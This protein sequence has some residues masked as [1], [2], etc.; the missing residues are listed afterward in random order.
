[1][2]GTRL[3]GTR[4]HGTRLRSIRLHDTH[5]ARTRRTVLCTAFVCAALVCAA[6]VQQHSRPWL[7]QHQ[8]IRRRRSVDIVRHRLMQFTA[9]ASSATTVTI[10]T[11]GKYAAV[12]ATFR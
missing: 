11:N 8:P 10:R 9:P 2:H 6:F 3:R 5:S 12:I 1:L 7:D 4:L